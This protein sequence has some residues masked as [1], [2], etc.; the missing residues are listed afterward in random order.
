[1]VASLVILAMI[2]RRAKPEKLVGGSRSLTM[3]DAMIEFRDVQPLRHAR[4]QRPPEPHHQA[5]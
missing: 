1:M 5:G 2:Q 3:A 4:R